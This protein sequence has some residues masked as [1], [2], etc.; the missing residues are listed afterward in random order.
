MLQLMEDI[1]GIIELSAHEREML[2]HLIKD[3]VVQN[4][5]P[6]HEEL[7]KVFDFPTCSL[8]NQQEDEDNVHS[9]LFSID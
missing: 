5:H 3:F 7:H 4:F 6:S 9:M 8:L 1:D 2:M